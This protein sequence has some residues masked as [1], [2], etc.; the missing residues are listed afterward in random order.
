VL[1]GNE[2]IVGWYRDSVLK[3]A[4]PAPRPRPPIADGHRCAV[5]LDV[6]AGGSTLRF[7]DVFTVDDGGRIRELAIYQG[8]AEAGLEP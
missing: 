8:Y 6:D 4:S 3:N 5:E 2:A 1:R 7:M